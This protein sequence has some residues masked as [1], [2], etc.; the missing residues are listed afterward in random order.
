MNE[1]QQRLFD[2]G[3]IRVKDIYELRFAP[4][5]EAIRDAVI[6]VPA[7]NIRKDSTGSGPSVSKGN[8]QALSPDKQAQDIRSRNLPITAG[9]QLVQVIEMIIRNSSYIGDQAIVKRLEDT[10]KIEPNPKSNTRGMKWFNIVMTA[11]QLPQY[12][13]ER[14]DFAYRI[15]YTIVPYELQE[16]NS[17][18]FPVPRFLGLHKRY[19]WWFTGQNTAVLDNQATINSLYNITMT[20]S[21]P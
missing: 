5:A 12:D 19:P 16:F 17:F 15:I 6:T 13:E 9:M 8:T 20:C 1:E 14:K 2:R 7:K 10:Q 3:E 4:G 18:Y 21:V 11:E